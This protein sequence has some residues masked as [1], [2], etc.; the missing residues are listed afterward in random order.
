MSSPPVVAIDGPS[1]SGKGAVSQRL[2]AR[3]EWHYLDSG[4]LYR[5]LALAAGGAGVAFSDV[6]GL[7]RLAQALDLQFKPLP[8]P[9]RVIL[10][11]EDVSDGIRSEACS[12]GASQVAAL[13]PVRAALL[14]KQRDQRR[15]PGLVADG[16]DMGTVVFPD[17]LLK[18]F[19]TAGP[20][21]R[22]ERRHKQLKEKGFDVN[23]PRLLGEILERDARDIGRAA[24]PLKPAEGAY[25][26]DTS[27]M[28]IVQV[29]DT[30][31][32]RL[33]ERLK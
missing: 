32:E 12:Q 23:L 33:R 7:T 18:V 19:L 26:L 28:T 16:R 25:I 3:L 5:A 17:A 13:G 22:A 31:W 4:A 11:G 1:G 10:D 21:V 8:P 2:A 30:I 24:S 14:Q 9:G 27:A 6:P 15:P 29:V 20:Q